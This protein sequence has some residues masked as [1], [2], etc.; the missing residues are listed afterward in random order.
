MH[1][2][3]FNPAQRLSNWPDC[4]LELRCPCSERVVMQPVRLLLERG[5]RT[6]GAVLTSLRCSKCQGKPAPVYLVAGHR[7]TFD[8]GPQPDWAVELVP[9]PTERLAQGR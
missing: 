9:P 2:P 1:P 7:R 8:H 3:A 4:V 5:D 6:F